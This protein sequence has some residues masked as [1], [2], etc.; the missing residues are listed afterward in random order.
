MKTKIFLLGIALV[1]LNSCASN[2]KNVKTTF[3]ESKDEGLIVGTICIENKTYTGYTFVYNDAIP[4]IADY[5]NVSEELVYKKSSG[6]FKEKGKSYYLFSIAKPQGKY[7]FAK[8]KIY[9]NSRE[10]QMQFE[11]PL[12]QINFEIVKGKTIYFGQ[13]T[14]NTQEKKFTVEN[15]LERDKVWFNKKAPQIQF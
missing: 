1:V 13:L 11:I 14:V 8:I 10:K 12:N 5:A 4:A 6:D 7:K 2:S 3:N 15:K 9:D